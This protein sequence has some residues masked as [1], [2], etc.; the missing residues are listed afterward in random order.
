MLTYLHLL[1]LIWGKSLNSKTLEIKFI[2]LWHKTDTTFRL[3]VLRQ[4]NSNEWISIFGKLG[5]NSPEIK[6]KKVYYFGYTDTPTNQNQLRPGWW[7]KSAFY[8]L[9]SS[10]RDFVKISRVFFIWIPHNCPW[11]SEVTG[12]MA[13]PN[14]VCF[15]AD[16]SGKGIHIWSPNKAQ[17]I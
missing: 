6:I 11:L 1:V 15:E 8:L 17:A 7:I 14:S 12:T 10:W 9:W 3:L 5:S 16:G 13:S 4:A 2:P